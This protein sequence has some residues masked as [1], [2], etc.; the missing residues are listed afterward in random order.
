MSARAW[1]ARRSK[2]RP[3]SRGDLAAERR[4]ASSRRRVHRRR[5]RRH[6]FDAIPGLTW[7]SY[8]SPPRAMAEAMRLLGDQSRAAAENLRA[9][10]DA[11]ALGDRS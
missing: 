8:A 2:S 9:F 10:A 3:M 6:E 7:T 11:A 5:I 4:L 1:Q